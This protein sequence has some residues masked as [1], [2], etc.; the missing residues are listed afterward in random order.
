MAWSA[1][2]MFRQVLIDILDG[3][4]TTADLDDAN[5]CK[6][7][8]YDNDITPDYSVS[9]AN[10]AYNAGQWASSGNEVTS[11]G[12][13]DTGGIA[14][15]NADVTAI[16]G[17][18]KWDGDDTASSAGATMSN[19]YGGLVYLDEVT[20]PVANQGL[21]GVYFGGAFSVTS[22]VFTIQWNASGIFTVTTYA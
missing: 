20:T 3:T 8:L 18:L 2:G 11:T 7:A 19:I 22:G 16:A 5:R 15:A 4:L 9:A 17:G 14:I 12:E 6:V 13:W 1:S 10:S 21:L